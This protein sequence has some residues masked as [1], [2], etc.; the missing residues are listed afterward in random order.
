MYYSTNVLIHKGFMDFLRFLMWREWGLNPRPPLCK[1]VPWFVHSVY[2]INMVNNVY[3]I[4]FIGVYLSKMS[5]F[6]M[7]LSGICTRITHDM[8]EE[9][10][11][12]V[13]PQKQYSAPTYP[14]S[15]SDT[16]NPFSLHWE[17]IAR[18]AQ[19]HRIGS[20]ADNNKL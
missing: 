16:E 5:I 2:P 18:N 6:S 1:R 19:A 8:M 12:V 9:K 17:I 14:Q 3:Q 11:L 10:R 7:S 20:P 13:Y 15:C 4:T